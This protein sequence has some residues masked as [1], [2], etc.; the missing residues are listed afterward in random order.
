M[1][2]ISGR[3]TGL[4][5]WH[6]VVRGNALPRQAEAADLLKL[7][8]KSYLSVPPFHSVGQNRSL[9][10]LGFK[11]RGNRLYLLKGRFPGSH[12]KRVYGVR[13]IVVIFTNTVTATT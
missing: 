1:A 8:S 4:L 6:G 3:V 7:S 5:T 13:D 11:E 2:F 10:Q 9:G 12:F